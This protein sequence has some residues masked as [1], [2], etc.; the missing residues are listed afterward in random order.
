[1]ERTIPSWDAD[2]G[3]FGVESTDGTV[4]RVWVRGVGPPIVLVHGS[5]RDHT[6]FDPLVASLQA[7]MTT[8]SIDR[9]GFGGSGD[10]GDYSIGQEFRDVAAVVDAVASRSGPVALWGHSYGAGCAAGAAALTASLSRLIIYEPGLGIA[11]PP[12]WLDANERALA[13]GD[14]GR[15][16]RAVLTDI[17]EMSGDDVEATRSSAEW[18]TYLAAAPTVLREAR[19]ENDWV[20]QEDTFA[21]IRCP[22]LVLV[23]TETTPELMRSTLRAAAAIPHARVHVLGGHGHLAC[24][25]DPDLVA[26]IITGFVRTVEQAGF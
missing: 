6:I 25:T 21:G 20:Y 18:P 9:R 17:L 14:A 8:Y 5:L 10:R 1:M 16:V 11:Y 7:T 13:A 4:I 23:G 3:S 24:L 15:V 22:A 12:G 19:T 26:S 2:S